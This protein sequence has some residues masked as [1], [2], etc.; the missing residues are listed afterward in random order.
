MLSVVASF[1]VAGLE[2]AICQH[3]R[4]IKGVKHT[5][6]GQAFNNLEREGIKGIVGIAA[7]PPGLIAGHGC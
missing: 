2:A 1:F 6:R 4:E 7:R 3:G 5:E